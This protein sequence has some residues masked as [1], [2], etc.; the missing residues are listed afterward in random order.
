MSKAEEIYHKLIEEFRFKGATGK[1]TF[2]LKNIAIVVS[3]NNVVGII[4]EE[5][6]EKWMQKNNIP[7]IHNKGQS[8]PD[9]WLNMDSDTEDWLELKS[10]TGRPKF[11]IAIFSS[12]INLIL[13]K[14]YKLQSSYLLIK[15]KME[16][17]LVMI[18]NFWLKKIWEISVV[19]EKWPI[20]VQ[21]K[22]G[23]I[24]NIRPAVWYS[25]KTKYSP[26]DCLEDFLSAI[27]ELIY[28]YPETHLQA[29]TWKKQ[30]IGSY[31]Q[32]YGVEL[33]IPRWMDI[34]H[35]YNKK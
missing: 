28:I 6:L 25:N 33:N 23:V 10:F 27:E 35:K 19:S 26:F 20:K 15:Y 11:D 9:F 16:D 4:L 29:A 17:G 18:E 1:I 8:S 34:K 5:W 22:K 13:Q 14:P 12:F 7:H 32:H 24:F 30:L 2:T 3:Q 21:D 31:K